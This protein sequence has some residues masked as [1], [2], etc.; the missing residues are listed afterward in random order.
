MFRFIGFLWNRESSAQTEVATLLTRRLARPASPWVAASRRPGLHVYCAD[1]PLNGSKSF[2]LPIDRGVVLGTLFRR[3]AESADPTPSSLV[4]VTTR[5]A[6]DIVASAGKSLVANFWG[7]Y[8]A[9]IADAGSDRKW[10]LR[11]PAGELP[12]YMTTFKDVVIVFSRLADCMDLGLL[13]FTVNWSHVARHVACGAFDAPSTGL[14]EVQEIYPGECMDV[15]GDHMRRHLYWNPAEISRSTVIDEPQRAEES[16]RA[17]VLHCV[18]SWASCYPGILHLISGGIDSSTVLACLASAP[19]KPGLVAA[20]YFVPNGMSDERHY[21]RKMAQHTGCRFVELARDPFKSDFREMLDIDPPV[22]PEIDLTTLERSRVE[23]QLAK[24]N[25]AVAISTGN[26]GDGIFGSSARGQVALDYLHLHGCKPRFLQLLMQEAIF[27]EVSIFKVVA[28]LAHDGLFRQRETWRNERTLIA[29][30]LLHTFATIPTASYPWRSVTA[31]MRPGAARLLLG[32]TGPKSFYD[33]LASSSADAPEPV[34]PLFSQP[35][36]ELVLCIPSYIM[37]EG[38]VDRGLVRRAFAD[39]LPTEITR[40]QWKDRPTNVGERGFVRNLATM[41]E[42]LLDG[43]LVRRGILDRA[44]LESAL[45]GDALW[46]QSNSDP[47]EARNYFVVEVW[48]RSLSARQRQR[49][50]A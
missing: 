10:V 18:H 31:R 8:V 36:G 14:N 40:R 13:R 23:R 46:G 30:D 45:S 33:E 38:G 11:D 37:N 6:E 48:L 43:E 28:K 19:S 44:R 42:L 25:G 26:G 16:I 50:A 4:N 34:N 32:F 17:T 47:M 29:D 7:R 2:P 9:F 3:N 24:E 21:A 20:N 5:D 39:Q 35:L 15:S 41:R 49:A 1:V 27:R 12:C 22:N